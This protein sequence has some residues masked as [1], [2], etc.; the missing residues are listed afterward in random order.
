MRFL[1]SFLS[2]LGL[3]RLSVIRHQLNFATAIDKRLD[4]HRELVHVV[5]L[6]TDLLQRKRWIVG[7]LA[8]QDDYLM[9]IYF[10]VHG[11]WPQDTCN[12]ERSAQNNPTGESVRPRPAI[13]GRCTL[14]EYATRS[15]SSATHIGVS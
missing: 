1:D 12:R 3:A 9:R 10:M 11:V 6:E 2:R 15:G 4:E 13:L 14:P 8:V 7:H 5:E